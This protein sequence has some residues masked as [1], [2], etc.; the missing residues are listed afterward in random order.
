MAFLRRAKMLAWVGNWDCTRPCSQNWRNMRARSCSTRS[1]G[2]L[3][4]KCL[5]TRRRIGTRMR[6]TASLVSRKWS[7]S[8]TWGIH[9]RWSTENLRRCPA[10]VLRLGGWASGLKTTTRTSLSRS[11]AQAS[12]FTSK[13]SGLWCACSPSLPSSTSQCSWSTPKISSTI[14][15]REVLCRAPWRAPQSVILAKRKRYVSMWKF[16]RSLK[17][18]LFCVARVDR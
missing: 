7:G 11:W 15:R 1:K 12:P 10:A 6:K 18:N 8:R 14:H 17:L 3:I 5:A 13:S 9:A 16:S 2:K 4:G